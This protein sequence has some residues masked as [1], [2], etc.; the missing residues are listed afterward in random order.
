MKTTMKNKTILRQEK[1]CR[2]PLMKKVRVTEDPPVG[3]R[4]QSNHNRNN[5]VLI[6]KQL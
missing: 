2:E 1:I 6:M 5:I 4:A 3:N